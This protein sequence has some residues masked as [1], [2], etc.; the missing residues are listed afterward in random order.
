MCEINNEWIQKKLLAEQ[1]LTYQKALIIAR[2]SETADRDLKE[3]KA[4]STVTIK[5][6]PVNMIRGLVFQGLYVTGVVLQVTW[7]LK[8]G[9]RI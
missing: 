7:Q 3:M 5:W 2:G 8:A 9:P 4:P 6:E 1:E